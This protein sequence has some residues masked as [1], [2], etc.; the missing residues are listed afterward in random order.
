MLQPFAI[1]LVYV[2]FFTLKPLDFFRAFNLNDEFKSNLALNPLQNF[3]TTLRFRNPDHNS[4]ANEYYNDMCRFLQL[5]NDDNYK[6]W[7]QPV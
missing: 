5:Q 7:I 4:R 3:F 2:W 6:K 1:G